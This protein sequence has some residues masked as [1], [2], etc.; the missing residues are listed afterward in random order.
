MSKDILKEIYSSINELKKEYE[1][2]FTIEEAQDIGNQMD[3]WK[4]GKYD[5]KEFWM[6]LNVE[7]EHGT[8]GNWNITN[9]D[10]FMTAKIA[11]VHLDELPDYYTRLAKMEEE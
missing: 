8:K 6:G 1:R 11:L 2:K 9:N 5:L 3:I 7:L 4:S 10:A